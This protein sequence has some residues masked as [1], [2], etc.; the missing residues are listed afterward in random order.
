M[1][2]KLSEIGFCSLQAAM[3]TS[4]EFICCVSRDLLGGIEQAYMKGAFDTAAIAVFSTCTV[5]V[6]IFH[7]LPSRVGCS[8]QGKMFSINFRKLLCLVFVRY[9]ISSRT[10]LEIHFFSSSERSTAKCWTSVF[11]SLSP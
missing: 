2:K 8:F 1:G 3:L 5:H 9:H 10:A 6:I 4:A 7:S 11:T